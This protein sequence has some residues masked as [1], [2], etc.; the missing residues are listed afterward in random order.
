MNTFVFIGRDLP[1]E[2]LEREF[3]LC[4]AKP[5]RFDIGTR[6]LANVGSFKPGTV[7]KHWDEGNAYR[8]DVEDYGQVFARVDEDDLVKPLA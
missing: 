1:T 5:L 6:V 2:R 3:S 8:I 4:K 7:T